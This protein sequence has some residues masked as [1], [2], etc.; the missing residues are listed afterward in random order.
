VEH[1]QSRGYVSL[2]EV[3]RALDDVKHDLDAYVTLGDDLFCQLDDADVLVVD[4]IEGEGTAGEDNG[5]SAQGDA[6]PTGDLMAVPI[7]D[8]VGMYFA[9]VGHEA[10]LRH[11]E[12]VAL[13][14]LMEEGIAAAEALSANSHSPVEEDELR[15]V[16][17]R[18]AEAREH[19]IRANT[20]LVISIAKRYRGLGLPFL[21]LMQ[22][23]NM[24]LIR[25][26]DKYDYRRGTKFSTLATWWIRQA[27]ARA[28]GK[29]G[30]TIRIPIHMGAQLRKVHRAEQTLGQALGREPTAEE[31]AESMGTV[32]P[33]RVRLMLRASQHPLSLERPVG[34]DGD[35]E[36][37]HL[38]EDEGA[39]SPVDAAEHEQLRDDLMAMLDGLPSREV[40]ALRMRFGLDGRRPL[41]LKEIGDRLGV[42]R[43]RA[44]QIVGRA[45]RR[46][47]HPS[48]SR[49]LLK[50]LR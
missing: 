23:G 12:E 16:V 48:R 37:G 15:R 18:G 34:E 36:L 42:T 45:L 41:A 39:L 30:R 44:R 11:D 28:V 25:A 22:A 5:E 7:T 26:A 40:L 43:E 13:A 4:S 35:G 27:V 17:R 14:K 47:R 49:V 32:S 6:P 20:R 29:H 9:E 24:G 2:A 1:G 50:Y 3:D 21:D 19:L 46:L 10:L 33:E 31:I 8:G 38:I